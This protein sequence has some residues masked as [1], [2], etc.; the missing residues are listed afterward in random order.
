MDLGHASESL[1]QLYDAGVPCTDRV[2]NIS[3]SCKL[4]PSEF[5]GILASRKQAQRRATSEQYDSQQNNCQ[6]DMTA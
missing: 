4:Q 3:M 1:K 5:E 6:E 2:H